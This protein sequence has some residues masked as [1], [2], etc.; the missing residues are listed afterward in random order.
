MSTHVELLSLGIEWMTNIVDPVQP[1]LKA[2]WAGSTMFAAEAGYI[3]IQQE[4]R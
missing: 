4:D 3:W 1:A 2:G